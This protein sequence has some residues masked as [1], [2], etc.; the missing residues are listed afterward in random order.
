[1]SG[2]GASFGGTV[3]FGNLVVARLQKRAGRTEAAL[4]ASRRWWYMGRTLFLSTS[5]HEEARLAEATGDRAGAIR[6]YRHYLALRSRPEPS[7]EA[8]AEQARS[9]LARLTSHSP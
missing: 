7:L 1:R 3:V 4:A 2:P 9:A 8:E 6:A 5:L